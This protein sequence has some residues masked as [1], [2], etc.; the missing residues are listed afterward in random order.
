MTLPEL[1]RDYIGPLGRIY[2]VERID[3][4]NGR[5]TVVIREHPA[6]KGSIAFPIE[7]TW[8]WLKQA[9]D[10]EATA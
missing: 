2:R 8:A 6:G 5:L 7:Q 1:N 4:A 3:D 9:S 10:S